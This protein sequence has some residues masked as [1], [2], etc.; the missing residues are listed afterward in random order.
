M[1]FVLTLKKRRV[2]KFYKV[3]LKN[4]IQKTIKTSGVVLFVS[5]YVAMLYYKRFY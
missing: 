4:Y 2:R 5:R 3:K 1:S